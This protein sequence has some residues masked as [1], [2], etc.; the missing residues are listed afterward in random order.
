MPF[1]Q[2]E[3]K[4]LLI[5]DSRDRCRGSDGI[6]GGI[7]TKERQNYQFCKKNYSRRRLFSNL[8][9]WAGKTDGSLMV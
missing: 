7:N 4:L 5:K 2:A 6:G 8:S 1:F 9:L 3:E